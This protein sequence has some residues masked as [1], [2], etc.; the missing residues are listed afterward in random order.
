MSKLKIDYIRLQKKNKKT[1]EIPPSTKPQPQ[2]QPPPPTAA[3]VS[4]SHSSRY[5][6][7]PILSNTTRTHHG[8]HNNDENH[9]LSTQRQRKKRSNSLC[10]S[11]S[12]SSPSPSPPSTH[13]NE[14]EL[15]IKHHHHHHHQPIV[16]Q[17][18]TSIDNTNTKEMIDAYKRKQT[19]LLN[20]KHHLE[21]AVAHYKQVNQELAQKL[22]VLSGESKKIKLNEHE[23]ERQ[24]VDH[25]KQEIQ[26]RDE[27]IK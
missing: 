4:S 7:Q 1:N 9:F 23:A 24:C 5:H 2:P 26:K 13:L 10:Y 22:E 3:P 20:E 6:F 14:K 12:T 18:K 27:L 21:E 25:F 17:I 19:D 8:H 16:K 11:S 15:L